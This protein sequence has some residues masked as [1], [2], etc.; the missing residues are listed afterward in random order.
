MEDPVASD[1]NAFTAC[2]VWVGVLGVSI[3]WGTP[4]KI[5]WLI[6]FRIQ[7]NMYFSI[8]HCQTHLDIIVLVMGFP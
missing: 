6:I 7:I 3:A 5:L 8:P 2:A 4:L 1:L